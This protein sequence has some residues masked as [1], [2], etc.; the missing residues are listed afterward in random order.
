M[1]LFILFQLGLLYSFLGK[2][3][4]KRK[5]IT[6]ERKVGVGFVWCE[7]G[8]KGCQ[9]THN[10]YMLEWICGTAAVMTKGWSQV[11]FQQRSF[12][13]LLSCIK[14]KINK[15]WMDVITFVSLLKICRYL[16]A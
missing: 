10:K 3:I 8:E 1:P 12:H 4:I 16:K 5:S 7:W 9:V 14:C 6:R 2:K 15:R 11:W 13:N